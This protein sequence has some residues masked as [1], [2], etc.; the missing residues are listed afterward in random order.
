MMT[1]GLG[2]FEGVGRFSFWAGASIVN[3]AKHCPK[4]QAGK[5]GHASMMVGDLGGYKITW[6]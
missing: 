4:A 6:G 1:L 5:A 3:T 2:A